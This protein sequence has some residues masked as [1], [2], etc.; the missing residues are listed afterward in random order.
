MFG[1]F[2]FFD[3]SVESLETNV[4]VFTVKYRLLLDVCSK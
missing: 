3:Y 2:I 1:D 4:D